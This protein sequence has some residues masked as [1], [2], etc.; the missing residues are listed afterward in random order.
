MLDVDANG[1]DLLDSAVRAQ[2]VGNIILTRL[3]SELMDNTFGLNLTEFVK[4]RVTADMLDYF[5]SVI[6]YDL[7]MHLN[8]SDVLEMVIDAR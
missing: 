1:N 5:R 4:Q 2:Y 7:Q 8:S 6:P 3:G